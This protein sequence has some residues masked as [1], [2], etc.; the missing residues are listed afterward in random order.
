MQSVKPLLRCNDTREMAVWEPLKKRKM[1]RTKE[2]LQDHDAITR[3][4]R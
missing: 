3:L 1:F 2:N 4:L